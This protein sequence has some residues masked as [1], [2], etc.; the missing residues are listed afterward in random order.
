MVD[1]HGY[2][3]CEKNQRTERKNTFSR[4]AAAIVHF[5][6]GVCKMSADRATSAA[7][8]ELTLAQRMA[9]AI[10]DVMRRNGECLPQDLLPLGF[11]KDETIDQ[12]HKAYAIAIAEW[13]LSKQKT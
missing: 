4:F 1:K 7:D 2:I 10:V 11:T 8:A 3:G 6:S 13:T 9:K 5:E 12:W